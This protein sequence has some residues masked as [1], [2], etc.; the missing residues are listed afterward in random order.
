VLRY[1][2]AIVN[3]KYVSLHARKPRV[4]TII[5]T[6]AAAVVAL[7]L[8]SQFVAFAS[9]RELEA[10]ATS[11]ENALGATLETPN[12]ASVAAFHLREPR[13]GLMV[14]SVRKGGPAAQAGIDPGDLVR[15][16]GG[17]DVHSLADASRALNHPAAPVTITLQRGRHYANVQVKTRSPEERG[18]ASR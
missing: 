11:V 6:V 7:L 9:V 16:I 10:E 4:T 3:K 13:D 5:A 15:R 18:R 14:T 12:S 2:V 1:S 8:L 17:T